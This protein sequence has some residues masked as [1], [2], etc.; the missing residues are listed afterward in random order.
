MLQ[1]GEKLSRS[2]YLSTCT[3]AYHMAKGLVALEISAISFNLL[4]TIYLA[5][6][7]GSD[8]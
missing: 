6:V 3:H 1:N 7:S 5:F 8:V 4:F 2:S